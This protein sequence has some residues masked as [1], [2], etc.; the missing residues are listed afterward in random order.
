MNNEIIIIMG[1]NAAGKSTL[2]QKYVQQGYT[3]LNRDECGGSID[4]V[5]TKA[6]FLINTGT[7]HKIVLDN[8]YPS[9]KSRQ[10]IVNIAKIHNI[11]IKCVHLTTSFEDAQFNACL[12]MV[13]LTGKLLQPDDFKSVKNPNLFPPAAIYHYRKE[14]ENPTM[15]EGFSVIEEVPFVRV[16]GPEYINKALILDYDGTLR[17][18]SGKQKY[19]I[20]LSDINILDGRIEKIR[21]YKKK[22]YKLLGVSNQ[23]G[24]AK[25]VLEEKV[26]A[27][28]EETNKRLGFDI[29]YKYCPHRIPP[30][31]CYCRKPASGLGAYFIE[32]YKLNPSK[33]IMVGDMTTDETFAKRCGFEYYDANAFFDSVGPKQNIKFKVDMAECDW[34]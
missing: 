24:I 6:E 31:S 9:V 8:T 12:R 11:P 2:V 25:G 1:Y 33:C 5:A 18:S 16:W 34:K 32:K 21:E 15:A 19:P 29:E 7:T 3:R 20:E 30:V 17:L 4:A 26:I 27:C 14:F 23:S 13:K 22:G 10:H 28:F